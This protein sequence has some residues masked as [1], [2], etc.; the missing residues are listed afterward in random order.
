MMYTIIGAD[1]LE[2]GPITADQVRQ[3]IAEGRANAQTRARAEG[4]T[5]WKPLVEYRE[6]ATALAG[7]GGGAPGVAGVPNTIGPI[8]VAPRNNPMAIAGMVMG[9]LAVTIAICCYGFPFNVL[10]IIFSLVG[11][12]QIKANPNVD[13][14]RGMAIA[15]LV[16]GILSIFL[17]V[18][19][20]ICGMAL[21]SSDWLQKLGKQ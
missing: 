8:P 18:L 2:Y 15:G 11:L 13:R 3:W 5:E 10:A 7:R 16:L 21:S 20:F 1:G 6:F 19:L 9:I 12:S 17:S 4:A 14:G